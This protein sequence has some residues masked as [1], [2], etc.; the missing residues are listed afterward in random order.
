M[1]SQMYFFLFIIFLLSSCNAYKAQ[2]LITGGT[3]VQTD[4][5]K[6]VNYESLRNWIIVEASVNGSAKKYKFLFDTGAVSVVSSEMVKELNLKSKAQQN[7]GSSNSQKRSTTFT[8]LKSV[9]I[10]GIDFE[11]I[12]AVV[13]D[14]DSSPEITCLGQAIDG[15]IG[16]NLMKLAVWQIDYQNETLTFTD[17]Q[18]KLTISEES[19][20]IPFT[21]KGQESPKVWF[22]VFGEKVKVTFDTGK[23]GG[24]GI[25]QKQLNHVNFESDSVRAIKG[26]GRAGSGV[27][28]AEQDTNYVVVVNDLKMNTL[29]LDTSII[30]VGAKT[31]SLVGNDFLEN[32]ITTFNWKSNIITLE[33]IIEMKPQTTFRSFGMGYTL[34]DNQ[35]IV[36]YIF[37]NSPVQLANIPLNSQILAIDGKPF[38][39]VLLDEFCKFRKEGL[40]DKDAKTV[41]LKYKTPNDEIK[42]IKL[43][44]EKLL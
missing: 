34:K 13:I 30:K 23:I 26:Y 7:V 19:H 39:E 22:P 10:E 40:V 12:G 18:E 27:F 28:G 3:I 42:S 38:E 9:Q 15:I 2:Q 11:N 35:L 14:F 1:K 5:Y 44:K 37:E 29:N 16:A 25:N 20:S 33:P 17:S 4:F 21:S 32:Y 43:N 31:G 41:L 8:K 6:K 24:I 36:S